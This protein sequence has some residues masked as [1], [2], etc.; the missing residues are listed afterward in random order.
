MS[1]IR[2]VVPQRQN[3]AAL[4]AFELE[5]R[6]FFEARINARDP[7]YYRLASVEAAIDA[8]L[9]DAKNDKGFGYLIMLADSIVGRINL[10]QIERAYYN[11][12]QL[13]YRLAEAENGKGY[14]KVAIAQVLQKAFH[15]HGLYRIEAHVGQHNPASRTVLERNGFSVFG[16]TKQGFCLHGQWQDLWHLHCYSPLGPGLR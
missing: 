7:D 10:T 5:N 14:A 13:G 2:L 6:A 3:A 15:E 8:L 12:A 1:E 9:C 16:E 11:R 4:L